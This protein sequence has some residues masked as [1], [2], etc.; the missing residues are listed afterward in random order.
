[1]RRDK[2]FP[3]GWAI[4][5]APKLFIGGAEVPSK[6]NPDTEKILGKIKNGVNFFQTQYVFKAK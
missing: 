3:S 5:P 4:D 6:G 1:M 2:K